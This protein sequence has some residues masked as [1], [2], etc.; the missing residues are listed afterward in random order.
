MCRIAPNQIHKNPCVDFC[1][2]INDAAREIFGS[3][4]G[5]IEQMEIA[6]PRTQLNLDSTC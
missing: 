6:Q 4:Q 3:T 5:C 1:P 2:E